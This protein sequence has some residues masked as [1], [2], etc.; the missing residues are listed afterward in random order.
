MRVHLGGIGI[1]VLSPPHSSSAPIPWPLSS[2]I[3]NNIGDEGAADL[4]NL[5]NVNVELKTL[6]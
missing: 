6:M 4:S 2:L 5:L 3:G 1:I